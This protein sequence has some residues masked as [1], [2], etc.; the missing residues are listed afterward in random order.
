[1][2]IRMHVC[3]HMC[4]RTCM[5]MCRYYDMYES[6]VEESPPPENTPYENPLWFIK[7]AY[8]RFFFL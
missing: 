2:G 7:R 4:M 8:G 6:Y 1:M 3:M 5:C